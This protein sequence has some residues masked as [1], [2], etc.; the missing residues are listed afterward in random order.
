[1]DALFLQ[2]SRKRAQ[3][4]PRTWGAIEIAPAASASVDVGFLDRGQG[5]PEELERVF[6][7]FERGTAESTVPS[8]TWT[9]DCRAITMRPG[10]R[11]PRPTNRVARAA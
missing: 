5:S 3:Y 8:R 9:G 7:L 6:E 2:S 10:C 11:I 4:A 1:M